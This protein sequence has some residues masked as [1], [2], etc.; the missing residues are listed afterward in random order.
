MTTDE[1][2]ASRD[3]LI[4]NPAILRPHVVI[5]GAG[6][7][8]AACPNGDKNGRRL[9]TMDNFVETLGLNSLLAKNGIASSNEN[10]ETLYSSLH[11][12][13]F[14]SKLRDKIEAEVY[15]YFSSLEL[16]DHPT[17][18]D[19]LLLSLRK[20]DAVFTFN[21]D[22]FFFDAWVRNQRFGL[23]Q[24]FFL[25]GNVRAANCPSHPKIW[26]APWG[27]CPECRARFVPTKLLYP[28][29]T[30]NYI[31]DPFITSRW[32][33]A[34]CYLQDAFTLTIFGYGAP[35]SDVEA[36]KLL[37]T[38]WNHAG[39]RLID[40]VEIIDRKCRDELYEKWKTFVS[41]DHWSNQLFFYDSVIAKYPRRSSE[42]L[43][44]PTIQGRPAECFPIPRKASFGELY[45]WLE[46]IAQYENQEASQAD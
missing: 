35:D 38:N 42:A 16:P 41:Y 1:A 36:V 26:G 4:R 27:H 17:I 33:N 2:F 14:Q 12:N 45:T 39:Q 46:P 20:K 3:E 8:V 7:S 43:R 5:L 9:P 25:H 18:Y 37:R 6:A 29:K 15:R 24:I 44:A 22:P 13:P 31:S 32:D 30:K 34:R 21:W 40:R 10:F 11:S 23:P 19:H 28:V